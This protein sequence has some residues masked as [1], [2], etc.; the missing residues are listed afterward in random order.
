MSDPSFFITVGVIFV[1][2]LVGAYLRSTVKDRCLK[3]WEGF[4]ITL[5]RTNGKLIWG[6]MHLEP[7]GIE[8]SYL[9]TVQDEKHIESTYLLYASEYKEIQAFYRYADKLS[10]WGKK[11]RALD[12]ERSFHPGPL[13]RLGRKTRNFLSTATDSLNDVISVVLGRVQ[14]TGGQYLGDK[15]TAAL[16]KLGGQV[17]GQAGTTYDPL[18]ER[19]IGHRVVIELLEGDEIHEHVGIFKNYSADFIEVLE[20]QYPQ[21]QTLSLSSDGVYQ[22]ER[23][24]VFGRDGALEV[25]NQDSWPILIVSCKDGERVDADQRRCGQRRDHCAAPGGPGSP[26]RPGSRYRSSVSLT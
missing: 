20:V 19:Y 6:V 13:R 12:I 17:I 11:H 25:N 10:E 7:S 9:D 1:V 15:G 4:H 16:G 14:K 21:N 22:S 8:L 18:L 24:V 2:A 26:A 5:E 3:S 23:L